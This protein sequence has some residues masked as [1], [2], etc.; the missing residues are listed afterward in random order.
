MNIKETAVAAYRNAKN[1]GFYDPAPSI[2]SRLLL[3][4]SEVSEACEAIRK[5]HYTPRGDVDSVL[6]ITDP[7]TFKKLFEVSVKNSFEDEIADTVIRCLDLCEGMGI[8]LEAHIAAKMR[9]NAMR[10][11]KHGKAF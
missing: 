5:N 7:E 2:E 10:P 11:H 1:K 8:D 9:Y 6:S 3:I 4:H